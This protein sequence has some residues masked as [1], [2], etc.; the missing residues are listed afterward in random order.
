MRAASTALINFLNAARQAG[1]MNFQRANLFTIT[2]ASGSVLTYTDLDVPVLWNGY[3]YAANSLRITGLKYRC[4]MGLAVDTQQI[5]LIASS[6][7]LY[8]GAL[9]LQALQQGLFD[10]AFIKRELAFFS[11]FGNLATALAP[12]GA[13]ILFQGRVTSIDKMGRTS[14][15][16]TVASDLVLL[17]IDMP[18]NL[19]QANC[20][21][22]LYDQGCGLAK[23]SYS[24]SGVVLP[25]STNSVVNW[26]GAATSYVQGT[27]KFTSGA[28][29]GAE[30]TVKAAVASTSLT[31][32]YPLPNVPQAGDGFTIA[33]GCDH[34]MATCSSKFS[35]LAHFRGFPFVPPPQIMTGPLATTYITGG[36]K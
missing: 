3:T 1:A 14:A 11:S 2:L 36:G 18:R 17:D 13:T 5:T 9:F 10:G 21:H 28:N 32:A 7:D 26:A 8:G 34:T 23:T 6:T 35:N 20:G 19:Y 16:M 24:T 33:Q 12:I 27:I 4:A 31:L 30:A 29:A 25:G 15:E 22:V